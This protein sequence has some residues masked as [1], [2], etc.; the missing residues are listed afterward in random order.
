VRLAYRWMLASAHALSAGCHWQCQKCVLG[1]SHGLTDNF[2]REC[3]LHEE[4]YEGALEA[5]HLAKQNAKTGPASEAVDAFIAAT[6]KALAGVQQHQLG[7]AAAN[8]HTQLRGTAI[9]PCC[10]APAAVTACSERSC[11]H[12][13][14]PRT[15]LRASMLA[16]DGAL[17]LA[18]LK[19]LSAAASGKDRGYVPGPPAS[20][21]LADAQQAAAAPEA[22]T[23][24]DDEHMVPAD[25][26]G[27]SGKPFDASRQAE[28][29][30]AAM[31]RP[32]P[33]VRAEDLDV[34]DA[35]FA[36]HVPLE[37][38]SKYRCARAAAPALR[39]SCRAGRSSRCGCRRH[40]RRYPTRLGPCHAASSMRLVGH[41][42]YI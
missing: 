37:Q 1:S 30:N 26:E 33:A 20:A 22:T 40:Q 5:F 41:S 9:L 32:G 36:G 7:S 25:G 8:L 39:S 16:G 35:P 28:R 21:A 31:A 3:F 12:C 27:A 19:P 38:P 13:M 17:D 6:E 15:S 2:C 4:E 24:D 29:I 14:S 11:M 42:R 18:A 34:K 23:G 10:S